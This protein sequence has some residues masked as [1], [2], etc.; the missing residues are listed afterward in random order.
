MMGAGVTTDARVG[1]GGGGSLT[2]H[3]LEMWVDGRLVGL[4]EGIGS[5]CHK[6]RCWVE[7]GSRETLLSGS[8]NFGTM[9]VSSATGLTGFSH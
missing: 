6:M 3:R 7:L 8:W 9:D 5:W 1:W 2:N 4:V